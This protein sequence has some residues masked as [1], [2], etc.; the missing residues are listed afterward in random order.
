M[1]P[2]SPQVPDRSEDSPDDRAEAPMPDRS[3]FAEVVLKT[4]PGLVFVFDDDNGLAW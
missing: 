3:D 2:H 1:E 4:L